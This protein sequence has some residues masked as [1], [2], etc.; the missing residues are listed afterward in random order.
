MC[1]EKKYLPHSFECNA[2]YD[3]SSED[4][5]KQ[6][7]RSPLEKYHSHPL[8]LVSIELL[9]FKEIHECIFCKPVKNTYLITYLLETLLETQTQ[10]SAFYFM[11]NI[12]C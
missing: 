7:L 12:Q 1:R 9:L 8:T 2:L 4:G 11:K 3:S 5:K 6:V 10:L